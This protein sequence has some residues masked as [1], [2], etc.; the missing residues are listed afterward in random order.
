MDLKYENFVR[1]AEKRTN[2]II[3][4]IRLLGNLAN[5]SNYSYKEDQVEMIFQTIEK[6]LAI[7][8]E[9]FIKKEEH[10]RSK[11]RL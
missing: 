8:K 9:K 1:L 5:T 3:D 4:M 2:K 7:Q 10:S 6:E 11:F